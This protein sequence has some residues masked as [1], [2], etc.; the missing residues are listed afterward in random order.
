MAPAASP[1]PEAPSTWDQSLLQQPNSHASCGSQMFTSLHICT[2]PAPKASLIYHPWSRGDTAASSKMR[3]WVSMGPSRVLPLIPASVCQCLESPDRS[4]ALPCPFL[5]LLS[6]SRT[7]SYPWNSLL[8]RPQIPVGLERH[9]NAQRRVPFR[10]LTH[11]DIDLGQGLSLV[12]VAW[13]PAITW[14]CRFYRER[15]NHQREMLSPLYSPVIRNLESGR[16]QSLG[17]R[18]CSRSE[19]RPGIFLGDSVY[20]GIR[21]WSP[22]LY[23]PPPHLISSSQALSQCLCRQTVDVIPSLFHLNSPPQPSIWPEGGG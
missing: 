6:T 10:I 1:G 17:K 16:I 8:P 9:L 23:A 4:S 15:I 13:G 3:V 5:G 18:Q 20:P 21:G 7:P 12:P 19:S 22:P 2:T 11:S 14:G